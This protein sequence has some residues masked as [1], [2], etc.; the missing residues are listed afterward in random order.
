MIGIRVAGRG[1]ISVEQSLMTCLNGWT[2]NGMAR[3]VTKP[4]AWSRAVVEGRLKRFVRFPNREP[5]LGHCSEDGIPL[6]SLAFSATLLEGMVE[7]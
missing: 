5:C 3:R 2:E 6:R 7:H 4:F 1:W